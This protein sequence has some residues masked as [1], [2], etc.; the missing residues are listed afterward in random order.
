VASADHPGGPPRREVSALTVLPS[1]LT[2]RA[3]VRLVAGEFSA[4]AALTGEA[5]AITAAT[6]ST[7]LTST[8]LSRA[9]C[10]A[11]RPRRW[12]CSRLQSK[13]PASGKGSA[14][15]LAECAATVL[16]HGL[17]RYETA[18][19]AAQP[20][21]EYEDLGPFACQT[22]SRLNRLAS[23]LVGNPERSGDLALGRT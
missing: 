9:A 7:P 12:R 16:Y 2:S 19:A 11:G 8:S 10:A 15:G 3:V 23:G 4:A 6:G 13:T 21:C 20:A 17:G 18:L 14:I 5:D 1:A 22:T